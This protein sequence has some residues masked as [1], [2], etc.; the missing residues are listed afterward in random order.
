MFFLSLRGFVADFLACLLGLIFLLKIFLI[1][2]LKKSEDFFLS[3][4]FKKLVLNI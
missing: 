2:L 1:P 3:F 4:F